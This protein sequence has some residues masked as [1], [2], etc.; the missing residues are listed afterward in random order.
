MIGHGKLPVVVF[1]R[2]TIL[3]QFKPV[4]GALHDGEGIPF[5]G[6]SRVEANTRN[7]GVATAGGTGALARVAH[8]PQ[9]CGTARKL[10]AILAGE[11]VCIEPRDAEVAA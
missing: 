11:S 3:G 4:V 10:A 9:P 7:S 2:L 5:G 6:W 1:D 8:L